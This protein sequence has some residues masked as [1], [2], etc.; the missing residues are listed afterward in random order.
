MEHTCI[1]RLSNFE[2]VCLGGGFGGKE[3]RCDFPYAAVAVAAN[4][5]VKCSFTKRIV[6][7]TLYMCT[8]MNRLQTPVRAVLERTE[9]MINTGGRCPFKAF[10]KVGF[11]GR[12]VV[13]ALDVDLYSN[14][15]YSADLSPAVSYLK[16]V[17]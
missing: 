3:L 14:A 17:L 2:F 1:W 15:G 5:Y 8:C 16:E 11:D 12:G 10:Y 9:D 4:K 7:F 13:E 6:N